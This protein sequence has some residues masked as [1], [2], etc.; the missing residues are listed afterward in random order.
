VQTSSDR[1]QSPDLKKD[2]LRL[3]LSASKPK[4]P[5]ASCQNIGN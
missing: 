5:T 1:P 4:L 2:I 3:N